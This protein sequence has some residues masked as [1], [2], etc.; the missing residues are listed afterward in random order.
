MLSYPDTQTTTVLARLSQEEASP[1]ETIFLRN[2]SIPITAIIPLAY[3]RHFFASFVAFITFLSI[4]IPTTL[5][6][7]PFS[8]NQIDDELYICAY[9]SMIV[10]AIMALTIVALVIWRFKLPYL[11]RR[12]DSVAAIM[13]YI[14]ASR[15]VEDF[16]GSECLST[17][18]MQ[19][20]VEGLKKRY[21]YGSL[22]G[23]D[24]ARRWAVDEI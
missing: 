15:M 14:C 12:P 10:L 20:R 11:P 3:R 5:S 22:I 7:I 18:M 9:S 16:E 4:F 17:G 2:H 21:H 6:G 13:S 19:K 1:S 8:P 24:G 23:V